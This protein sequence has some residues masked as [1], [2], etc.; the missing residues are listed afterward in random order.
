M[1]HVTPTRR[2]PT[3]TRRGTRWVVVAGL[4]TMAATA[5]AACSS[6]DDSAPVTASRRST[7][8]T[9]TLPSGGTATTTPPEDG[10]PPQPVWA[11][12][13][14]GAGEDVLRAVSG[15]GADVVAVGASAGLPPD[16]AT[17]GAPAA[18]G[19][20]TLTATVASAD[21]TARAVRQ[22]AGPG[23]E[24]ATGV[25]AAPTGAALACGE[26]AGGGAPGTSLWCAA[27][28][29]DGAIGAPAVDGDGG[30]ARLGGVAMV[31]DGT[32]SFAAASTDGLF[33]GAQDPTGGFLGERDALVL[34]V[35]DGGTVRWARQ[36][37]SAGSDEATGAAAAPDGDALAAGSTSE[38]GRVPGLGGNDAWVA[39]FDPSGNQR[40]L[41]PFGTPGTDRAAAVAIGGQ[42]ARGTEVV[43]AA[44]S[45]DGTL[46]AAPA[47]PATD[48]AAP[49][50][51]GAA[52]GTDAM[53]AAFDSSGAARWAVQWGSP[54]E[55]RATG[56]VVDGDTVLVAGTVGGPVV[57]AE[58]VAAPGAPPSDGGGRDGFLAAVDTDT[59]RLRWVA[60][61]GTAGE[62][63]VTG[64][65]RTEDGHLVV[66]GTTTGQMTATPAAGGTDGFLLAFPPPPSGGGAASV[67]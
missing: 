11:F 55:D 18:G 23:R 52:G 20:D 46:P 67:L 4:V 35:D 61:F 14:G 45:T 30:E 34:R 57:G 26:V 37:G 43:V 41:T 31:E 59:G 19:S 63:E 64:L 33:P 2:R 48:G 10:S 49:R 27:L 66:S 32:H 16:P 54:G 42:A 21:G 40:W 6:S 58:R 56:V 9:T 29:A 12:Q 25:T 24:V 13:V 38:A 65:T 60:V 47:P 39:R 51:G 36:F 1:S 5:V 8:T 3:T 7:T 15:R 17:G 53:V 62:E 44:G 50:P 28:G 22:G